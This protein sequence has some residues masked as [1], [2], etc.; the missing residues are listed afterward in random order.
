MLQ[1]RKT[2]PSVFL[3]LK[4]LLGLLCFSMHL[5]AF[6]VHHYIFLIFE[7]D[8][9]YTCFQLTKQVFHPL[10]LFTKCKHYLTTF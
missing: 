2:D 1:S 4:V 5:F 6:Y 8:L 7:K 3:S 10:I 9:E